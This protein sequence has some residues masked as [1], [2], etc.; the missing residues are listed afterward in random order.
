[1]SASKVSILIN[2]T[3][4]QIEFR[5]FFQFLFILLRLG[6]YRLLKLF[7]RYFRCFRLRIIPIYMI[8]SNWIFLIACLYKLVFDGSNQILG[9]GAIEHPDFL[10]WTV[11]LRCLVYHIFLR[12]LI[13]KLVK[14]AISF[15][16]NYL[17][18]IINIC[19]D[20]DMDIKYQFPVN[21]PLDF[22]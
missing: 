8:L 7:F 21:S 14:L 1:M 16:M 10:S 13:N 22:L 5:V 9:L 17:I 15:H 18:M 4:I 19:I 11:R 20:I 6:I 2:F 12:A 3:E